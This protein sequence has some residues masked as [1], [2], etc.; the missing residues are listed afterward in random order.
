MKRVRKQ[1]KLF[2][3][4]LI[5]LL[6]GCGILLYPHILQIFYKIK[7]ES[8]FRQFEETTENVRDAN[9]EKYARLYEEMK[10][11]N[12]EL[13][14]NNQE[15]LADPY[16]YA[17]PAIRLEEYGEMELQDILKFR[18]WILS[19]RYIWALTK[20]ICQKELLSLRKRRCRSV[21]I[22][23]I[24]RLSHIGDTVMQRCFVRLKN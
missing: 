2:I 22:I 6:I 20:K 16:A 13:I 10:N 18:L 7:T 23:R 19:F 4:G 8:M 12:E 24:W 11:Y 3:F 5:L 9:P 15:N 14:K 1:R 21:G 17:N